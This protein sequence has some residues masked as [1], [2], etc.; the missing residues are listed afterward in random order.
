MEGLVTL[1][2]TIPFSLDACWLN[3]HSLVFTY[4][5][6]RDLTFIDVN[7][8]TLQYP[9]K[10]SHQIKQN[11]TVTS[12]GMFLE[13]YHTNSWNIWQPFLC[14]LD[15]EIAEICKKLKFHNVCFFYMQDRTANQANPAKLFCPVLV[16]PQKAI[17]GI[18][19]LSYFWNSLIK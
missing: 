17:F 18:Q 7:L 13:K 12:H 6:F 15:G 9:H 2:V 3:K 5:P 16:C 10:T 19:F 8:F 14:L 1:I 11:T 4:N